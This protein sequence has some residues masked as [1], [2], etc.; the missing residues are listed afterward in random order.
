MRTFG[1]EISGNRVRNTELSPAQRAAICE[2][3]YAG[4]PRDEIAEEFNVS[5]STIYSTVKRFEQR[6]SLDTAKRAG[7]PPALTPREERAV[8]LT[9][10]RHPKFTWKGLIAQAPKIVSRTTLSRVLRRQNIRKWKAKKRIPLKKQNA[11]K[12]LA[13]SR[14]WRN[15][16]T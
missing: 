6:K 9:A 11:E 4:K 16:R 8:F 2:S 3:F 7:R 13:F 14:E 15:F 1:T 10:R 5:R 12:R